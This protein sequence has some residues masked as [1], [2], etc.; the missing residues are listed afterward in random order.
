MELQTIQP[1]D[2]RRFLPPRDPNGHKG[3]FGKLLMICGSVGYTG[4]PSL[5]AR[6]ALRCGAGMVTL[7]VP[8][9]I[10]PIVAAK[11]E[12]PVIFPMPCDAQ[13]RLSRA[14]IPALLSRLADCDACLIGCGLG[15]SEDVRAVVEAV[16]LASGVPLVLDADGLNAIAGHIDILRRTACP[17][18]LTPHAGEFQRLG[19]KL[20]LGRLAAAQEMQ[21]RTGATLLLKGRHTLIVGEDAAYCNETGNAGMA[22]GGCGDVLAGMI[23]AL[24]GQGLAPIHAAALGAYLH[25]AAGDLCRDALGEISMTPSDLVERLP[26]ILK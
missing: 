25:G 3:D 13:G 2:V 26:Q 7:C 14:A 10:Y 11:L 17:V 18:I 21:E 1:Q 15:R 9:S 22:V 5:A 23:A 16:L 6:G 19:G 8:E 12:E 20:S 4:A 24:L